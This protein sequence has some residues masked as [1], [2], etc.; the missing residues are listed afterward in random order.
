MVV[1][2]EFIGK[3]YAALDFKE[4]RT[5]DQLCLTVGVQDDFPVITALY[6]LAFEE[7]VTQDAPIPIFQPD[8]TALYLHTYRKVEPPKAPQADGEAPEPV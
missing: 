8:G 3:V 4:P 6:E 7:K 5:I 2:Q 1:T